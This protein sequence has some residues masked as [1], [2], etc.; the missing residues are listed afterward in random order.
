VGQALG[1]SR[2]SHALEHGDPHLKPERPP[3]QRR[4]EIVVHLGSRS[5]ADNPARRAPGNSPTV[6][7]EIA[8]RS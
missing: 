6:R 2:P 8:H 1:D 5:Y 7:K 3:A 4:S